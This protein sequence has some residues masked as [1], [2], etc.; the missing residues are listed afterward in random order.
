MNKRNLIIKEIPNKFNYVIIL[1]KIKFYI[2]VIC[3]TYFLCKLQN[4]SLI[5]F[6]T[7]IFVFKFLKE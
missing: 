5:Y 2:F 6:D 3:V 4:M 1:H 7:K